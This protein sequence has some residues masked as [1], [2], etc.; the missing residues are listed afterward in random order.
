MVDLC[1]VAVRGEERHAG[2][3]GPAQRSGNCSMT[4]ALRKAWVAALTPASK[5]PCGLEHGALSGLPFVQ[6]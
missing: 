4:V 6:E 2:A 5:W 1:R 3:A